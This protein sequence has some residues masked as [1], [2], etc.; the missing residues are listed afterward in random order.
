MDW[1]LFNKDLRYQRVKNE[2][3]HK[4]FP[5]ILSKVWNSY[6]QED[7]QLAWENHNFQ[8]SELLFVCSAQVL[9][10]LSGLHKIKQKILRRPNIVDQ[11]FEK[12]VSPLTL[13]I[14]RQGIN[15]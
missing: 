12:L 15:M 6:F 7:Y 5:W 10:G 4:C 1:F 3:S 2:L 8:L 9:L 13:E 11:D 14:D